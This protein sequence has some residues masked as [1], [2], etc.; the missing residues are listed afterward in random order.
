MFGRRASFYIF[1]KSPGT[2]LC[3]EGTGGK[4]VDK[5]HLLARVVFC[6]FVLGVG[7]CVKAQVSSVYGG[8][9]VSVVDPTGAAVSNA[10]VVVHL[11]SRNWSRQI[12]TG[13][14]G[15]AHFTSLVPG[16]YAVTVEASD[17]LRQ[18]VSVRLLL[19]H[20]ATLKI[21]L[22]LKAQQQ[23]VTI[24]ASP[25]RVD[26]STIPVHTDVTSTEIQGLPINQRNF[27][28]F[29][30]LDSGL[31]RD[32]LR[33]HAV[34][35]SS[36]FNVMGQRP[37]S[38]SLQLDGADLN[39]ETTGGVRGSV[40]ME[41][42][43]EFQVLTSGYQAEYGRAA[44]GVVNVIT[45]SG[46]NQPH[47]TL[48]GF[49]RH[50]SF[51]ATNAFS[52]LPDPPYTRTQYGLSLGGPI[53]RDRTFFFASLEQMRRQESGFSRIGADP[54]VFSLTPAQLALKATDPDH[55]AVVAA[56]R[57]S[58]IAQQGIDPATG[59]APPYTI[60]LL[61]GEGGVYPVSQ[62]IG[63]YMLRLDQELPP[64]HRLTARFNYAHDSLS[65]FEA[66]NNDQIAGLL[67][68]GRTAAL[69]TLDPTVVFSLNS[70][71]SASRMN[72]LRFSWARRK[73]DMTPN[74]SGAPVNIPGVAFIGQESILP[75][76][77]TER[78]FHLDDALTLSEGQH[79]LKAGG[80]VMLCPDRIRYHRLT[81][82]QFT[83][84]PQT[85]P[86]AEAGSP[87]LTSIQAYGL[88]L[89]TNF[90][91]QFGDPAADAGKTSVGLF[92]QDSWRMRPGL[93]ADFSLRYDVESA[94][95]L[96]PSDSTLQ[97][98]F[99]GLAIRRSPPTDYNNL[100]PRVGFAYQAFG[101]G[102]LTVRASY[103]VFY[104]RLLNLSTYLAAV[105]DG[106]QMTRI[107]LPGAAAATVFQSAGQ[108]L[109]S[110]PEGSTPTG[111][112][113]FSG[114]WGLGNGQQANI[115]FSSEV[116]HGLRLEAGYVWVKGTHLP[117]SR[118]Y[119]SQDSARAA[120]FLAAGNT[121][122]ELLALNFFRPVGEVSEV[123]V[124]ENSASSAYHGLRLALRGSVSS[125]L[126]FNSSYTFS[127]AIDDA[128]E[129]FP[130]TR[131][132]D[133][134]NLRGERGLALYDQRHRFVWAMVYDLGQPW[135]K[136]AAAGTILNDWSAA[137]IL[138]L[139]SGRPVNVLLGFDNN[140]DQEPGSDRPDVVPAGTSG[141][142]ATRYGAF[143]VPALG[144]PGNL[145]RNAFVG[146][147][148][149]SLG[150]RLQKRMA[151]TRRLTSHFIVEG[152][153]V[154]NR[155]NIRAVNPN[156]ERAGEPL[157]AF[158]ARQIQFG[159]RLLF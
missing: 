19:G 127:K 105:G 103:G 104:D 130:H 122:A 125:R 82:G 67:S 34:A 154:F 146:P 15:D 66:Q 27:L 30:L 17:F 20:E 32:T 131:A 157:A 9:R 142:V 43:Q 141:A 136:G 48:F 50:R 152:F 137:P 147:G 37:R 109:T 59:D 88:G 155:R 83:F 118:D 61:N 124:F 56:E 55:P 95:F 28:D 153:N 133:M 114:G 92:M 3:G 119:N 78:H 44:G 113:A 150:L 24:A 36:G 8:L 5:G 91:Q 12:L 6:L 39:D 87:Q 81:N 139:G 31:Q 47:G 73:F 159:L 134:G 101:E 98:V 129:I 97:P 70:L 16:D 10:T 107:I 121:Q 96:E 128:E 53:R 51:D 45:K 158:D 57:G 25:G 77:R 64:A 58:A 116:H 13:P 11:P 115:S 89:A 46:T 111:L 1:W 42:V 156:Y 33:V 138:E 21:V 49:L 18:D 86:G 151:V 23:Q 144:A 22:Q 140:L 135:Q 94:E 74:S 108:R 29:A 75:H 90:V 26:S 14:A 120:A 72:D 79:T 102:R 52:A 123:M 38:N 4:Q 112:I 100:Q 7:P 106:G 149:A 99:R 126:T 85:A 63:S 143:G 93:T 76:Y 68:P 84:G 71:F 65:S 80:D 148:F 41:A 54:G 145:G 110:Y 35:V 62:R 69:T 60:T 2:H 40:P 117:R 132:Q